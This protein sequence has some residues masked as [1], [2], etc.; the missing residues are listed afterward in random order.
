MFKQYPKQ[1]VLVRHGESILNVARAN[2]PILFAN[3]ADRAPFMGVPD[4][5]VELTALGREQARATGLGLRLA[6]FRFDHFYD[7]GYARTVETLDHIL[8]QLLEKD[9]PAP[10]RIHSFLIRERESGYTYCMTRPEV[11]KT[12]PWLEEYWKTLGP[13]FARPIGGESI[14][15]VIE[16]VRVFL[17]QVFTET[18]GERVLIVL[19]GRVLAAM[20]YL[21][22]NWTYDQLEEFMQ[23]KGCVNCGVTVYNRNTETAT[24]ELAQYNTA[25]YRKEV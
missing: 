19:H 18:N 23:S 6:G 7:S 10:K 2:S 5:K 13:V 15:D 12:F 1:L 22:E 21:L 16:R 17:E 25:Y 3:Q 14:A 11:E 8:E 9:L 24:L 4:H 20:R